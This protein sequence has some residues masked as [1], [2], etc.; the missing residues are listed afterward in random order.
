LKDANL[1]TSA[2]RRKRFVP[3]F[4]IS[5]DKQPV[6]THLTCRSPTLM[7]RSLAAAFSD[8]S[9]RDSET[10]LY[11][12]RCSFGETSSRVLNPATL[13]KVAKHHFPPTEG[14]RS[15]AC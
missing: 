6:L 1:S 5:Y 13:D 11:I 10:R 14:L 7:R 2:C 8:I 3:S 9:S 12:L 4:E 15:L